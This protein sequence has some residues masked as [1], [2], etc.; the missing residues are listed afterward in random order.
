MY[1]FEK[2]T[3]RKYKYSLWKMNFNYAAILLIQRSF[4][5]QNRFRF[6]QV[7]VSKCRDKRNARVGT[8]HGEMYTPLVSLRNACPHRK[9]LETFFFFF[10]Q[11]CSTTPFLFLSLQHK[12]A[13]AGHLNNIPQV[14]GCPSPRHVH[15]PFMVRVTAININTQIVNGIRYSYRYTDLL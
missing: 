11:C 1:I 7:I 14:G 8:L 5:S 10:F 4:D 9:V 13:L 6:V 12:S 2:S 3:R 15:L